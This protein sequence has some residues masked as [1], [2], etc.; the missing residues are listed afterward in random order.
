MWLIIESNNTDAR[1]KLAEVFQSLKARMGT[2]GGNVP[3][4]IE[5]EDDRD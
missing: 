4:V 3:I 1:Y 2:G 5:D